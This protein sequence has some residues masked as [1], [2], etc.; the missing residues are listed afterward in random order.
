MNYS[1]SAASCFTSVTRLIMHILALKCNAFQFPL[2]F[3]PLNQVLRTA[4]GV[5]IP[6]ARDISATNEKHESCDTLAVCL[7]YDC[8][9]NTNVP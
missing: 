7:Y 8:Y 1:D 4:A 6:Y 3:I 2:A 9:Q 5:E